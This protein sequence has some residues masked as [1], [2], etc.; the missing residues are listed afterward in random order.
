MYS[1]TIVEIFIEGGVT[2]ARVTSPSGSRVI[3]LLLLMNAKMGDDILVE[4]DVA[5]AHVEEE[6]PVL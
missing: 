2:K 4:S 6:E 3:N 1:G 5:V